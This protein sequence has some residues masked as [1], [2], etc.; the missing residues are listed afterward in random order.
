MVVAAAAVSV[1][2][3]RFDW[4]ADINR[5]IVKIKKPEG[6]CE[7][8]LKSLQSAWVEVLS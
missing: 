8:K 1:M 6:Q 4:Q 7:S 2:V 3:L 5:L